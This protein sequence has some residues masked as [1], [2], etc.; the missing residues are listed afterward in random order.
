VT[1]FFS[2]VVPN[3]CVFSVELVSCHLSGTYDFE[4]ASRF[5][6]NLCTPTLD[7]KL[8]HSSVAFTI[9]ALVR[10]NNERSA[11]NAIEESLQEC[12]AGSGRVSSVV[13]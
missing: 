10:P 11:N 8:C 9:A 13:S 5:V 7:I 3:I 12:G 6:G 1:I 2:V 4:V